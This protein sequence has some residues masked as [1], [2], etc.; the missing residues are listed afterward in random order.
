VQIFNMESMDCVCRLR[1]QIAY[2]GS[3]SMRPNWR[4]IQSHNDDECGGHCEIA[5]PIRG[6]G[7][8]KD[9]SPKGAS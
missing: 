8:I 4:R 1:V 5:I 9:D 2:A 3:K 6:L 7:S